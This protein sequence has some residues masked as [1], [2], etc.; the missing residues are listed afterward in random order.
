MSLAGWQAAI[1]GGALL[2]PAPASFAPH[3][4]LLSLFL[5]GFIF[6]FHFSV[7]CDGLLWL[8]GVLSWTVCYPS[9]NF[10]PISI[11]CILYPASGLYP[12]KL[13]GPGIYFL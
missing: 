2:A 6:A 4:L 3:P 13:D 10:C 8:K 5:F 1:D 7:I 12:A 11:L 9:C